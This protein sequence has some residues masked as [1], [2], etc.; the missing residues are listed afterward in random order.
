MDS[1]N[2][3]KKG[4]VSEDRRRI[5]TLVGVKQARIGYR[6]IFLD[7]S[8]GECDGC[9]RRPVCLGNLEAKRVY[10]VI[11]VRGKTFPCKVHAD[12]VSVVEVVESDII[13]AV[14]KSQAFEG[15]IL[16]FQSSKCEELTCPMYEVCHPQGVS[17][18]EKC[19]VLKIDGD[20]SCPKTFPLVKVLLQRVRNARTTQ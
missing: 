5:V 18:G 16:T 4:V 19:K 20:L 3:L 6:F 7:D 13:A 10:Q 17:D 12:G 2:L 8:S 11:K 15:A 14:P 1:K 9:E